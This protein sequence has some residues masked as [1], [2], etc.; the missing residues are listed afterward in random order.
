MSLADVKAV[1]ASNSGDAAHETYFKDFAQPGE[2]AAFEAG[3]AGTTYVSENA[4]SAADVYTYA[5]LYP[6]VGESVNSSFPNALRY[7]RHVQTL[8]AEQLEAL[9]L[10]LLP[11]YQVR[12]CERERVC[13]CVSVCVCESVCVLVSEC[14]CV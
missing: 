6:Q 7:M 13:V 3:I 10:Q 9:G 8:C 5:A 14:V 1:L 11:A 2:L 4:F 12:V